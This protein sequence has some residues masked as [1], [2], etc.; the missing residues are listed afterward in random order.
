MSENKQLHP[1]QQRV[2]EERAARSSEWTKLV[3][4]ITSDGFKNVDLAEQRRLLRQEF[5][6]QLLL[7]VQRERI[8]AF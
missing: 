7:D 6:M 8:N 5:I 3:A 4:F 1:H 2:I